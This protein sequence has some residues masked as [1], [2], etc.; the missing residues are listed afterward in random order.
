[1][2]TTPCVKYS[3]A[4]RFIRLAGVPLGYPEMK[5]AVLAATRL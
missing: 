2:R 4:K 3:P 5:Q 1:M